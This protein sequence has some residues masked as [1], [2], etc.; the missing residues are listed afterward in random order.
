MTRRPNIVLVLFDDMGYADLGCYGSPIRTT[1]VDSI[2]RR[3]T[4]FTRFDVTPLCSPTRAALLTGRNPHA[5]GMGTITQFAS[6]DKGY[7]GRIPPSA[8][9]LPRVLAD[10]GYG[11]A[12]F[13]KWHLCPPSESGPGGPYRQWPLAM[14]FDRYFGFLAG[15]VHQFRPELVSDNTYVDAGDDEPHVSERIVD[16]AIRWLE[17][18]VHA[19]PGDPFFAMV[20]FGAVHSPHQAPQQHVDAYDGQFSDGWERERDRRLARQQEL[21]LV[22]PDVELPPSDPGVPDWESL[23][24][25]ERARS[26]R[27][28]SAYAGH[29]EHADVQLAR[30]M[31]AVRNVGADDDTVYVVLSDNGASSAGGRLG[32]LSEEAVLNDAPEEYQPMPDDLRGIG[33]PDYLNQYPAG[34]G[35]AS[36]T[37][38]RRYKNTVHNGGTRS[39]L[40][41]AGP[42]LRRG[43]IDDDTSMF[44]TDLMPTLLELAGAQPPSSVAGVEQLPLHGRS[45]ARRLAAG[46]RLP[47]RPPQY[48]EVAGHRA[49]LT[50]R[51]KAVTFHRPDDDFDADRWELYDLDADPT[52]SVD[53]ASE[54]PLLLAD[55]QEC[56]NR[57]AAE[58]DVFPL[59]VR[60]K[61]SLH[62]THPARTRWDFFPGMTPVPTEAAPEL[63]GHDFSVTAEVA[64]MTPSDAGVLLAAGDAFG[65]ITLFV[66]DGRL[67][68]GFNALGTVTSIRADEGAHLGA[69]RVTAAFRSAGRGGIITLHRDDEPLAEG[70]VAW[71]PRL[72]FFMGSIQCGADPG[73]PVVPGYRSPFPFSGSLRKVSVALL[74]PVPTEGERE[75]T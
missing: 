15:R 6:G 46:A 9:M 62:H 1:C 73:V 8:A 55:L 54:Q 36:N 24:P 23:T 37:P 74:T 12:L 11:T 19:R 25:S 28:M 61:E 40:I 29:L 72:R 17:D 68:F 58:F 42:G 41:I 14:G 64:P 50:G 21:G 33:G 35:Q 18:H 71:S 47:P 27:L 39:P 7:T 57:A 49:L 70:A 67:R 59:Q 13:G 30:L 63:A 75:P 4:R 2:A 31:E 53:R 43:V 20:A 3:G 5:V 48:L 16:E 44:V 34:W 10:S 66:Q 52:E 26:E 56:W 32:T 45:V 69:R 22:R 38:F 60:G 51:W 65:G